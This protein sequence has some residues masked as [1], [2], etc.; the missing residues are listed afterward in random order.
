MHIKRKIS[1][2]LLTLCAASAASTPWVFPS[3]S[4]AGATTRQTRSAILNH[5]ARGPSCHALTRTGAYV[6]GSRASR[7][8]LHVINTFLEIST[9][10]HASF[11]VQVSILSAGSQESGLREL[12]YG[13]GSS[14]GPLQLL[15]MHGTRAQRIR[16]D[17]S[18]NWYLPQAISIDSPTVS[19]A[20]MAVRVQRPADRAGYKRA[21][22]RKWKKSAILTVRNYRKGCK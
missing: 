3:A 10:Q 18:A 5:V 20:E 1:V 22:E 6:G 17:F 9:K 7:A 21:I 2:C 14:L 16:A 4:N 19:V 12:P 11:R 15:S 8:Q 13:T